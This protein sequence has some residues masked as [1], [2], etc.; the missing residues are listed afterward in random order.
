MLEKPQPWSQD[1]HRGAWRPCFPE[2]LRALQCPA[3]AG[4]SDS[5]SVH[6]NL[7]GARLAQAQTDLGNQRG[8]EQAGVRASAAFRGSPGDSKGRVT[9]RSLILSFGHVCLS[10]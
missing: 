6:Q 5:F 9:L 2:L 4:I 7:P 3:S 1:L 8:P 10:F